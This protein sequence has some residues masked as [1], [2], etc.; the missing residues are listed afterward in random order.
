MR[1]RSATVCLLCM[2]VVLALPMAAV[3]T[4]AAA[5]SDGTAIEDAHTPGALEN[6]TQ[7][8]RIDVG[9]NGDARISIIWSY[10]VEDD[11]DRRTLERLATEFETGDLDTSGTVD[12]F[13]RVINA[14]DEETDRDHT[15][16]EISREATVSDDIAT[17]V[18]SFE[19]MSFA[20]L[21]NDE[22][23]VDDA[24]LIG[25]ETWLPTLDERQQLEVHAPDGYAVV[26]SPASVVDGT[27]RWEGPV[28]FEPGELAFS[29]VPGDPGSGD[30]D[31]EPINGNDGLPLVTVG[32]AAALAVALLAL[33]AVLVRRRGEI[34]SSRTLGFGGILAGDGDI[35]DDDADAATVTPVDDDAEEI[36]P[37]LLSDEE[38]VIHLLEE[39]DGRM[40]Q[41]SIVKE[42]KW[43]NAKVSQLLSAMAEDG[44]IDKLRIGREN[45]ITLVE[46]GDSHEE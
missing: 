28:S 1:P 30:D 26:R 36:D 39:N 40:K 25:D 9:A 19:W 46:E 23:A 12:L 44:T 6:A 42:T 32:L 16:G 10:P 38:R 2:I 11:D 5:N 3:P 41:A 18:L 22:L 8:I 29:Y 27:V 35:D 37:E 33:A 7:T 15:M 31:S 4:G 34:G 20:R 45:L 21:V 24:F 43:S 14:V 17:L 13:D